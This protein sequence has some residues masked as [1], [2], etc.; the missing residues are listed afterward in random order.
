MSPGDAFVVEAL[1]RVDHE[2]F[3]DAL[4]SPVVLDQVVDRVA[5][6]GGVLGV[7]AHVEIEAGAVAEEHVGGAAPG[8]HSPEEVSGHFVRGQATLSPK[9]ASDPVL[10]LQSENAPV[11]VETLPRFG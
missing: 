10:G 8:D 9:G 5:L 4:T 2:A 3:E 11:H 7:G 1:L 6:G